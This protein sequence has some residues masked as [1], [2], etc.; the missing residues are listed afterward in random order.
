MKTALL[1]HHV[2]FEDAGSL[3]PELLRAGYN[4]ERCDAATA[5][6]G[7]IDALAWDLVVLLGGPIGVY[8]QHDFPFL[9]E[10]L[11]LLRKRLAAQRPT[12]GICLGS[13]L[14]AAALGARVYPGNEGQEIGWKPL[15]S[16]AHSADCPAMNHLLSPAVPVL[17]WHGDTFDLPAGAR[18]LA[19]T[20]QYAHQ[21][22]GI[23]N[24]ALGVQFH[25]EVTAQGLERWYV[26]HASELAHAG[27]NVSG[28]RQ[29]SQLHAP[30]LTQA[31][32]RFWRDWLAALPG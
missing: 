20:E 9:T 12:L 23:G 14:M 11:A 18:H 28:L 29:T 32:E 24:W 30:A 22:F 2:A 26:G 31:A 17:H 4:I 1:I 21:A 6:L 19:M 15:Q 27:I 5:N 10:E 25:P 13:Q 3:E 16:T 8:E 7:W